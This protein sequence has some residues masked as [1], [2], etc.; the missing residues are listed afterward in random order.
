MSFCKSVD[1]ADIGIDPD[2]LIAER[3]DLLSRAPPSPPDEVI[4]M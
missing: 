2:G 3:N 4:V 1:L